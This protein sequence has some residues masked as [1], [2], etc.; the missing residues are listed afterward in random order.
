[1]GPEI[2]I[3]SSSAA[4]LCWQGLHCRSHLFLDMLKLRFQVSYFLV[5]IF[6]RAFADILFIILGLKA[7]YPFTMFT[8]IQ[9]TACIWLLL[10]IS[11]HSSARHEERVIVKE[12]MKKLPLH[13]P[14]VIQSSSS[15]F[16]RKLVPKETNPVLELTHDSCFARV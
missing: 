12:L 10:R 11:L 14:E 1:M 7:H 9:R 3:C 13:H 2:I 6:Q 16:L 5:Q 8:V 4:P 15:V